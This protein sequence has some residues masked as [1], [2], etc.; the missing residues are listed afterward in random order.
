MRAGLRI[1]LTTHSEWLLEQIGNLVRLSA[2]PMRQ[3][4][5]I[6]GSDVAL[7]PQEV[8]AWLFKQS[9]RPKGSVVEEVT[10]SA[11]T[12]TFPTDYDDVSMALYNESADIFNRLQAN[13]EGAD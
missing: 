10:L 9:K 7:A 2:L 8:G 5:G 4:N 3:R 6:R 11:E 13:R 1:V 12:G